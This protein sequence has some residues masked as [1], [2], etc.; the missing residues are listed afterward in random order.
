[1]G[2]WVYRLFEMSYIARGM[3]LIA[4]PMYLRMPGLLCRFVAAKEGS[5]ERKDEAE[6]RG[7]GTA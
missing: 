6:S 2:A 1:M 7:N 4:V 3:L 5:Q